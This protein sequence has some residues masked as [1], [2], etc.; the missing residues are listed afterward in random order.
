MNPAPPVTQIVC[1]FMVS[2]FMAAEEYSKSRATR[3]AAALLRSMVGSHKSSAPRRRLE[4]GIFLMKPGA[5]RFSQSSV[6]FLLLLL[7]FAVFP[8]LAGVDRFTPM[9]P[10]NGRL[11]TLVVDPHAPGSLLTP[12]SLTGIYPSDD[13]G[14]AWAWSGAGL[15]REAIQAIP[16]DPANPETFYAIATTQ[17]FRSTD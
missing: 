17:A 15:G 2:F 9:G 5:L 4:R 16:A 3:I 7:T 10:M 14:H 11:R 12:P 1:C 6:L 8:A 13:G